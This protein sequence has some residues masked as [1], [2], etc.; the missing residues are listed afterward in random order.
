MLARIAYAEVRKNMITVRRYPIESILGAIVF[1]FFF[2]GIFFGSKY[3]A[4]GAE[5]NEQRLAVTVA[6]YVVWLTT[7]GLFSGPGAQIADDAR[8]GIL[9][10]IFLAPTRFASFVVVRTFSGLVHHLLLITLVLGVICLFT[11]VRLNYTPYA[12]LPLFCV[13]LASVGLGLLVAGYAM[14]IKRIQS[15]LSLGQFIMLALVAAPL[16]GRDGAFGVLA[17][18][19]PI[20]PSAHLLGELLSHPVTPTAS[21]YAVCAA[22]GV[23]WFLLGYWALDRAVRAAR[24]RGLVSGY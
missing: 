24:K 10:Q 1:T 3:L 5:V 13:I 9:E 6:T 11:G 16:Q 21:E 23:A 20:N 18:V 14:V 7:T 19:V 12:V 22:N 8:T 2:M 17:D 4:G 15:L